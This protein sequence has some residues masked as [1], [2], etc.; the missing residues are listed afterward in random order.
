MATTFFPCSHCGFQAS[1]EARFCPSCGTAVKRPAAQPDAG[2]PAGRPNVGTVPPPPQFSATRLCGQ[3]GTEFATGTRFCPHCGAPA[4][5]APSAGAAPGAGSYGAAAPGSAGY[6]AAPPGSAGYGATPSGSGGY[7]APPPGYGATPPAA[8]GPGP[9][10]GAAPF[11]CGR[12]GA[13]VAPGTNFCPRCGNSA[14]SVVPAADRDAYAGAGVRFVADLIDGLLM[15]LVF[16]LLIWLP[17]ANIVISFTLMCIYGAATESSLHQA[18]FGKRAMGLKVTDLQGR[19]LTFG[20]ALGRWFLKEVFSI[21]PLFWL[22]FLAIL[23]TDKKQG[24]HD[25]IAETVVVKAR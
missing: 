7:G 12:C 13:Q 18:S 15:G 17:I 19:R 8:S 24:V 9:Q 4:G 5:A 1:A 14:T 23:F 20:R 3:C 10:A 6:G 16:L 25:L 22:T 2:T 11:L 21:I